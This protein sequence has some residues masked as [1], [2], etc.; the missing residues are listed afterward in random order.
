MKEIRTGR[1]L[2]RPFR[3]SDYDDLFEFLFQLKDDEFEGYPGITYE[4][5]REHMQYRIGS[6]EFYAVELAES[7][8]VIGNIYYGNRDYEAKE[9][10]YIINRDYQRRGY[11]AEALSAVVSDAFREGVH[12]V[13]AE[14][15]P[16]NTASWKLLEKIGLKREAY[17][18][19][20]ICFRRD[21][22]GNPVWK[23]TCVY[24]I[25]KGDFFREPEGDSK[26]TKNS[27][28]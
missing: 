13:Y 1:L 22:E 19:Q 15:D 8:K 11:A 4:N 21:T 18:R 14:C 27:A 23:D 12:R 2:L 24:A 9:V 5:G 6:E 7:G 20:N 26:E 10:G 17:F 28:E 25:I 3:E 16:R